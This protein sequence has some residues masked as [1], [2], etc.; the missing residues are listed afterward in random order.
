[1]HLSVRTRLSQPANE[2]RC[3]VEMKPQFDY[4]I[5][6]R[7]RVEQLSEGTLH[8]VLQISGLP[9]EDEAWQLAKLIQPVIYDVINKF[10]D[11]TAGVISDTSS[12][13]LS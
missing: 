9:N 10:C 5:N 3:P 6:T 12:R 4:R 7:G 8:I 11:G 2:I 13:K 1:M